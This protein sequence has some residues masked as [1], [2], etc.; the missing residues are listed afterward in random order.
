MRKFDAQRSSAGRT[1]RERLGKPSP[2]PHGMKSVMVQCS[3][4]G[5]FAGGFSFCLGNSQDRYDAQSSAGGLII[6]YA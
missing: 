1:K 6:D 3:S 2:P 4:G 5:F